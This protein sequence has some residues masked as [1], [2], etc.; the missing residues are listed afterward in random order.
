MAPTR[1]QREV[2]QAMD[3]VIQGLQRGIW[4]IAAGY[5]EHPLV[6]NNVMEGAVQLYLNAL[7]VYHNPGEATIA[8][9]RLMEQLEPFARGTAEVDEEEWFNSLTPPLLEQLSKID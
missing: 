8:A 6:L 2:L 9:R 4:G 7:T 5:V 3:Y 1:K